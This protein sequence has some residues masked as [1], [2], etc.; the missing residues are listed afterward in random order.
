MSTV[1]ISSV[2]KNK[3][4]FLHNVVLWQSWVQQRK[5]TT[6]EIVSLCSLHAFYISF[7][8][9]ELLESMHVHKL[10]L[11]KTNYTRNAQSGIDIFLLPARKDRYDKNMSSSFLQIKA[12]GITKNEKDQCVCINRIQGPIQRTKLYKFDYCSKLMYI[13]GKWPILVGHSL[14]QIQDCRDLWPDCHVDKL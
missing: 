14:R 4:F 6:Y 8:W 9:L 5:L 12:C 1:R 11:L 3:R 2:K 10:L 7:C 13:L